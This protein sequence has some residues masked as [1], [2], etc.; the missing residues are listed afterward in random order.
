MIRKLLSSFVLLS[1]LSSFVGSAAP[2][3][4]RVYADEIVSQEYQVKAAFLYNFAKFVKWPDDAREKSEAFVIGI[5]GPDPFGNDIDEL[6]K[7]EKIDNRPVIVHRFK[8]LKSIDFCHV[9]FVTDERPQRL[10][11]LMVS[12]GD[13]NVLTV[14]QSENF[15]ENGGMIS[16]FIEDDKIRFEINKTATDKSKLQISSQLFKLARVVRGA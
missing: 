4:M 7:D 15:I 11:E 6:L 5:Y 16:F 1:A 10:R 8:N 2:W 14:G 12:L 9:L 13:K 3:I